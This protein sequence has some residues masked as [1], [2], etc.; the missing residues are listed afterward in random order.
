MKV[1]LALSAFFYLPPLFAFLIQCARVIKNIANVIIRKKDSKNPSL[2]F[3]KANQT[4]G[5]FEYY[6]ISLRN[7][8]FGLF[9]FFLLTLE[10]YNAIFHKPL[11]PLCILASIFFLML[12]AYSKN[13]HIGVSLKMAEFL[14]TNPHVHPSVFFKTT[15]LQLGPFELPM[16]SSNEIEL[17][18]PASVSFKKHDRSQQSYTLLIPTIIDTGFLAHTS[19]RALKHVGRDFARDVFD[20]MASMWG[21]RILDLFSASLT[22]TGAEQL[23][24]LPG[25]ILLIFNHK[26]QLDFVLTFFCLSHVRRLSGRNFRPR[27][28]TA[29]DQFVDNPFV[30]NTLG[31]GRL[32]ES[33]DMVFIERKKQKESIK[34][35]QQAAQF[36]AE[37]DI[38]IAIYPQGTRPEGNVDRS[39]KR[40]DAGYYTTF[41][42]SS[43]H[44]DD[45]HLKKGTAY[46]ACD[47][48]I[49]LAKRN[50]DEKLH[51]VFI[52]IRGTATVMA[53]QSLKLQTEVDIEYEVGKPITFDASVGE[54]IQK[55]DGKPQNQSEER[56][57]ELLEHI[58]HRIDKHLA[59]CLHINENLK[60]RYLLDLQGTLRFTQD[61]LD[62]VERNLDSM[63]VKTNLAYQILDRIY[64]LPPQHWN[65][66]LDI[67][68]QFLMKEEPLDRFKKFREEV[69]V[70]ILR[71]LKSKMH[72]KKVS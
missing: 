64:A 34:N 10:C 40:R 60:H 14:R 27:F 72:G 23:A 39:G 4:L 42:R 37:K 35:L 62:W 52:G 50:R 41:S 38:E 44:A 65:S 45:G 5:S 67:F 16:P 61:K 2:I 29:K 69:S 13:R 15:H 48:L 28:I 30:Y 22:T 55:P 8:L 1:F 25:K 19:L 47:T 7:P 43:M 31:V 21:K 68:A 63:A 54:Q 51:L 11:S 57:L 46:L 6:L 71:N 49:E 3:L 26:S 9:F 33:V 56:Y 66:K 59:D 36:L 12:N 70:E 32:I 20:C 18:N 58:H 17:V 53:K 24:D